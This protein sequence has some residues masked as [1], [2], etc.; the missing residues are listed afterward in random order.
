[1]KK[2]TCPK[3]H[4]TGEMTCSRCR[5]KGVQTCYHCHGTG[6]ACPVCC[7]LSVNSR[8]GYVKDQYDDWV[9]CPNCHGD[10]KNKKYV[11]DTCGGKGKVSCAKTETC[12]LCHGTG[13]VDKVSKLSLGLFRAFSMAFGFSGLQYLYVGRWLL[14]ALQFATFLALVVTVIFFEPVLSFVS[15]FGID[16]ECLKMAQNILG[17][18]VLLNM[19]LGMVVI[20]CDKQGGLLNDE[21]KRGWYWLFLL[22][23]GLIGAH[24]AYASRR[25]RDLL[26]CFLYDLV[27]TPFVVYTTVAVVKECMAKD[28][29][30]GDILV[31]LMIYGI[32]FIIFMVFGTK[33]ARRLMG[34]QSD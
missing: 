1:M 10:Y 14:F 26:W 28:M 17:A 18:C 11:C 12:S 13:E 8:P 7:T 23:F 30:K 5:G 15:Q 21:F 22:L 24:L 16:R 25:V 20:K 31:R 2:V 6:H 3:C 19:V 4:G 33:V 32:I 34:R 29:D 9:Y 27:Y